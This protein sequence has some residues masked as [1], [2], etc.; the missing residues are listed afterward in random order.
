MRRIGVYVHFPWCLKK[1]PYCDFVSFARAREQIDHLDVEFLVAALDVHA[2]S[3][4]HRRGRPCRLSVDAHEAAFDGF[5]RERARLEETR[6]P[7]PRVEPHCLNVFQLTIR[8]CTR[9]SIS[10]LYT[11]A[12]PDYLAAACSFREELTVRLIS[13]LL[14]AGLATGCA[15]DSYNSSG[16]HLSFNCSGAGNGWDDCTHQADTQCGAKGYDVIARNIDSVSG[17]SGTS[18]MKRELV[19]A[20]K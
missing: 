2:L 18:E 15:T 13:I 6:R 20:C 16:R 3:D 12:R 1:C 10:P 11:I 7:Q 5:F 9:F 4:A 14:F 19:V 8:Y 17:A